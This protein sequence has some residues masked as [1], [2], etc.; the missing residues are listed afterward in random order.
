MAIRSE[1]ANFCY[2]EI[3]NFDYVS[4]LQL[5]V[6]EQSVTQDRKTVLFMTLSLNLFVFYMIYMFIF[7][8]ASI[9]TFLCKCRS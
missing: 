6:T 7:Q 3:N 4:L 5:D 1:I 9:Q 2:L 8:R